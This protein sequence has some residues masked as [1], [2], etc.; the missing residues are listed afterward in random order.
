MKAT[1]NKIVSEI[2]ALSCESEITIWRHLEKYNI[3]YKQQK[4]KLS[5]EILG[6]VQA[7]VVL[8][9]SWVQWLPFVFIY[10]KK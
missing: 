3:K 7:S 4:V 2:Q 9:D 5:I 6:N 8:K 10:I 1:I